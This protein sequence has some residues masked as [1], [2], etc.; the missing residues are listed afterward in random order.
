MNKVFLKS[1]LAAVLSLSAGTAS[2]ATAIGSDWVGDIYYWFYDDGHAV[3][4]E[5]ANH[6]DPDYSGRVVI[7][8]TVTYNG[9]TYNVT[10]IAEYVFRDCPVTDVIMPDGLKK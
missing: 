1:L 8:A 7:P 5:D 4:H 9:T 3:V 10:E 6:R 2:A